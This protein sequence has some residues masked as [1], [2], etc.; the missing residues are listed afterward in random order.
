[1]EQIII[2]QNYFDQIKRAV[3]AIN[4]FFSS[5]FSKKNFSFLIEDEGL[6]FTIKK[7]IQS[8]DD[9]DQ[10]FISDPSAIDKVL[11]D[12][13]EKTDDGDKK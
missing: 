5:D 7:M 10:S 8:F 1:M 11:D 9:V 2:K 13:K 4:E 6:D 3:D 12:I